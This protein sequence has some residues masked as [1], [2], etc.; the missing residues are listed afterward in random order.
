[1]IWKYSEG[2]CF[3]Y[4]IEYYTKSLIF[5]TGAMLCYIFLPNWYRTCLLET[6][7]CLEYIFYTK[8]NARVICLAVLYYNM[9]DVGKS[10]ACKF[11]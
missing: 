4:I 5:T 7:Y 11:T 3:A 1:M 8:Y 6:T 2:N 9:N 10:L